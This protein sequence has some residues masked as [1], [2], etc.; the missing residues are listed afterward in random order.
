MNAKLAKNLRKKARTLGLPK[1]GYEN[2]MDATI[3][4]KETERGFYRHL[5]RNVRELMNQS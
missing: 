2:I 1:T 3:N 5:K 4:I